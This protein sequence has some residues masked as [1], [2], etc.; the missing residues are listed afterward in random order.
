MEPQITQAIAEPSYPINENFPTLDE[1]GFNVENAGQ[2]KDV[3]DGNKNEEMSWAYFSN[4]MRG[5][6]QDHLPNTQ[7]LDFIMLCF[8]IT[9]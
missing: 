6:K 5:T 1:Q 4:E 8:S 3:Y 9:F 7:D 2:P